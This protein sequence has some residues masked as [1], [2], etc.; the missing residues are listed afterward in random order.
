MTDL[1]YPS[2]FV[3]H[4]VEVSRR[5]AAGECGG[6]Y[7]D[8]ILILSAAISTVA[9]DLFPGDRIDR[10]RFVEVWT[11]YADP[12]LNPVRISVPLLAQNLY[13]S[14]DSANVQALQALRPNVIFLFPAM[15]STSVLN[16]EASD[17]SEHEIQA[18]CPDLTITVIRRFSYPT[19]FYSEIRNGFVHQGRTS[20]FGSS[21]PSPSGNRTAD[22]S[23]TNVIEKPYRRIHFSVSYLGRMAESIASNAAPEIH[24][25]RKPLPAVWWLDGAMPGA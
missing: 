8:A 21:H 24:L 3:H 23:Y 13:E 12:V 22:I 9:A 17:A 2:T 16:A 19:L 4:K 11:R 15:V 25:P 10:V 7:G 18:V 1:I 20:P 14:G 5:L 6:S